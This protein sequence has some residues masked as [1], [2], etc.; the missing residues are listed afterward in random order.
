MPHT[1]GTP[2]K[3]PGRPSTAAPILLALGTWPAVR[4][5]LVGYVIRAIGKYQGHSHSQSQKKNNNGSASGAATSLIWTCSG[6]Y[7]GHD[8]NIKA[9]LVLLYDI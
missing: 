3:G 7:A 2:S 5:S 9:A 6:K 1:S 8:K 4:G